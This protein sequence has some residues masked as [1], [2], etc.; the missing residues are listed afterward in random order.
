M[1]DGA[2]GIVGAGRRL[3]GVDD[4]DGVAPLE[5]VSGVA[6]LA[7]A[8]LPAALDEAVGVGAA[9]TRPAEGG[10]HWGWDA[11]LGGRPGGHEPGQALAG[12]L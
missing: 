3:A 7:D 1:V 8:L 10:L 11:S 2:D 12:R 6:R 9:G 5:G 4:L